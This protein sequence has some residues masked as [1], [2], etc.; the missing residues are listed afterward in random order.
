[1]R[2]HSGIGWLS[3]LLSRLEATP[4]TTCKRTGPGRVATDDHHGRVVEVGHRAGNLSSSDGVAAAVE[5]RRDFNAVEARVT[6]VFMT[7]EC[8]LEKSADVS[9]GAVCGQSWNAT[10]RN[11]PTGESTS[12]EA[13]EGW[14]ARRTRRGDCGQALRLLT[15]FPCM[16]FHQAESPL[17]RR[18]KVRRDD[19]ELRCP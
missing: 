6:S 8:S 3:R 11:L 7:T 10:G 1:M 19:D 17:G 13:G 4:V 15:I 14:R 18:R 9:G 16:T 2:F 12:V 5:V